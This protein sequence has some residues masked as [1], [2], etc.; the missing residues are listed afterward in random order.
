MI[1]SVSLAG[2]ALLLTAMAAN[3]AP[4][5]TPA[6]QAS[7][8]VTRALGSPS[9]TSPYTATTARE[10]ANACK[11]DQSSCAAM[12]GQVLMDRIQFSPTSHVCLPGTQYANAVGPWLA[13]HPEDADMRPNDGIYLA[14]T[15]IYK[16]G[17]P[18]N[19]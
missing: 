18:N 9:S 14:I 8:T 12:V 17:A 3:A 2:A 10:F 4:A 7:A 5:T 6:M 13:E 15:T 11:I 16:C 19:Y 1:K